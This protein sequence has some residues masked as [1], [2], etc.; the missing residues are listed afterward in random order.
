MVWLIQGVFFQ[1]GNW[2]DL[3]EG[4]AVVVTAMIRSMYA[5]AFGPDP[6]NPEKLVGRMFDEYGEAEL[7]NIVLTETIFSFTKKY[8]R[9]TD[10]IYY[11]FI[12]REDGIWFGGF[13]G[14]AVE[15]GESHCVLQKVSE[16]FFVPD[17]MPAG[18]A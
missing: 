12:K 10:L 4:Q 5:G 6:D 9:R 17:S 7:S 11:S 15:P 1:N 13:E 14:D 2:R 3:E 8:R 16:G 18:T